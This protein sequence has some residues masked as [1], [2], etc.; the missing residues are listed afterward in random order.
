VG[1][2]KG[3]LTR[4]Y[5]SAKT[6]W[7]AY[8]RKYREGTDFLTAFLNQMANGKEGIDFTRDLRIKIWEVIDALRKMDMDGALPLMVLELSL[9]QRFE[10]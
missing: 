3:I 8:L 1:I 5:S 4:R 7:D 10:S 6:A 9:H 2:V